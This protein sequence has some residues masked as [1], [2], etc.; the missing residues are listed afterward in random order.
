MQGRT[1]NSFW[2]K[3]AVHVAT[4]TASWFGGREK[5][6]LPQCEENAQ[7]RKVSQAAAPPPPEA[8]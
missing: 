8:H 4:H 3:V 1:E 5:H 2:D 7:P 6:H